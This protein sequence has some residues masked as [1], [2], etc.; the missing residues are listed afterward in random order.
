MFLAAAGHH[1]SYTLAVNQSFQQGGTSTVSLSA[2]SSNSTGLQT[3][4]MTLCTTVTTESAVVLSGFHG[5]HILSHISL[6][7]LMKK[8]NNQEHLYNH[9]KTA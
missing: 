1:N 2:Q 4:W 3:T 6:G 9:Q 7:V 8:K 5:D